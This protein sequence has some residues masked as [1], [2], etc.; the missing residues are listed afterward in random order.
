[1]KQILIQAAEKSPNGAQGG[2]AEFGDG[3]R[4]SAASL[5]WKLSS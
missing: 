2:F 1:M 4:Y 5:A 3:G